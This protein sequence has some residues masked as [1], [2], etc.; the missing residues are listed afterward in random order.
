MLGVCAEQKSRLKK[1]ALALN[2][3]GNATPKTSSGPDPLGAGPA[4][5]E[6]LGPWEGL[7]WGGGSPQESSAG[8][9]LLFYRSYGPKVALPGLMLSLCGPE[10]SHG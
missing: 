7:G 9:A 5:G 6:G 8:A 10:T 3:W 1:T 2:P 4:G